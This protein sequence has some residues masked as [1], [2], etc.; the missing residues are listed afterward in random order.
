[1]WALMPPKPKALTAALRGISAWRETHSAASVWTLK[2][3]WNKGLFLVGSLKLF[4]GGSL[5][6]F[7][8]SNTLSVPAAPAPVKRCP[9]LD[10]T[11]PMGQIPVWAAMSS[12]KVARLLNSI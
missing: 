3:L 7:N 6:F 9:M 4:D 12:H 2:G 5:L 11:E 10:F 8:A 1:M